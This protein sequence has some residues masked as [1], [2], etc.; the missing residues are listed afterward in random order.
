V[1][2]DTEIR[3][4]LDIDEF[5][6]TA[7]PSGDFDDVL[8]QISKTWV[9]TSCDFEFCASE[10]VCFTCVVVGFVIAD[11]PSFKTL[12]SAEHRGKVP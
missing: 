12:L 4:T 8:C 6:D 9:E 3:L 11:V 1:I 5:G 7:I 10:T 2:D